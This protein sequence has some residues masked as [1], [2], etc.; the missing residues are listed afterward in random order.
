MSKPVTETRDPGASA[1]RRALDAVVRSILRSPLHRVI[2]RKLL[3]VTVTGDKAGQA[4]EHP[5]GYVEHDG[6][7]FI[8]TAARWRHHLRPDEPVRVLLRGRA[9]LADWDV[10]TGEDETDAPYRLILWRNPAQGK[11]AGISLRADGSVDR[12]ELRA[13]L[14]NGLAIVILRPHIPDEDP[15]F[16]ADR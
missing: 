5:A 12:A 3:V 6:E 9:V 1:T 13:A 10:L 7:L 15:D 14:A 8:S 4:Y 11:R 16:P 2:S